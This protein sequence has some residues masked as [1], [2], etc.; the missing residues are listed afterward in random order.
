MIPHLLAHGTARHVAAVVRFSDIERVP[1][2]N[3]AICP[4]TIRCDDH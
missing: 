1:H 2:S 3:S 4:K